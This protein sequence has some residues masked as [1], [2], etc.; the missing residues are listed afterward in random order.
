MLAHHYLQALELTA[1][2]GGAAAAFA[3]L[4]GKRSPT[5]ASAPSRSTHTTPPCASSGPLSTSSPRTTRRA[6]LLLRLG[7]ALFYVGEPDTS[8]LE[9]AAAEF[10]AA[11]DLEGAVEAETVFSE[12]A[13]MAGDREL[14]RQALDRALSMPP[15]C[16]CRRRRRM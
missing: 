4:R 16:R 9:R 3:A 10:L 6:R 1:A 12:H 8:V 2:A 11:G 5:P 7:Q 14:A 13:W 15:G